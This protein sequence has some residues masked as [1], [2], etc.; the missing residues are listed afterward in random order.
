MLF[1]ASGGGVRSLWPVRVSLRM[2]DAVWGGTF[3]L[4]I[5][6]PAERRTGG[7]FGPP[8]L[9]YD[10]EKGEGKY[11]VVRS[12]VV[13]DDSMIAPENGKSIRRK[14]ASQFVY[15]GFKITV[16]IH[17]MFKKHSKI[18]KDFRLKN[19]EN[20]CVFHWL[21]IRVPMISGKGI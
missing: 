16:F 9:L 5:L 21:M 1:C 4:A 7:P 12:S 3:V 18:R 15:K 6:C 10:V 20:R 14:K 17:K 2:D 19:R 13:L 11:S 8:V